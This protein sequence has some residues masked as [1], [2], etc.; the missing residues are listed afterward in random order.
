MPLLF[1]PARDKL[2]IGVHQSHRWNF[3]PIK[4]KT[5]KKNTVQ[6][7]IMRLNC[8]GFFYT[9]T[10]LTVKGFWISGWRA[11]GAHRSETARYLKQA[12][13]PK[14]H[15]RNTAPY[16]A[17]QRFIWV[18]HTRVDRH[19]KPQHLETPR[20]TRLGNEQKMPT[21]KRIQVAEICS[22]QAAAKSGVCTQRH[23]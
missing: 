21:R 5:F 6:G 9:A 8:D 17:H 7:D 23:R 12:A 16:P 3:G 4:S 18:H 20:L 1:I 13:S 15:S 2:K 10:E 22:V 14:I 19:K 11:L